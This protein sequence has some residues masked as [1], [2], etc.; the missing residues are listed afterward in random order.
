MK[1]EKDVVN[2]NVKNEVNDERQIENWV[3]GQALA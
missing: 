3:V 1:R 2:E